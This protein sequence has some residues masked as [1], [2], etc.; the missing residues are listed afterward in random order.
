MWSVVIKC[1]DFKR[2]GMPVFYIFSAERK[3][4][5]ELLTNEIQIN[6]NDIRKWCD[7]V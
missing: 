2:I 1:L 6:L 4:L 7:V 3:Y 5:Q